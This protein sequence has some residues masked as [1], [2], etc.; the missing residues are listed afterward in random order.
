MNYRRKAYQMNTHHT[1]R[2]RFGKIEK[3]SFA[4]A[5]AAHRAAEDRI[6]VI[7]EFFSHYCNFLHVI[8]EINYTPL[9]NKRHPGFLFR[10]H[11]SEGTINLL[12]FQQKNFFHLFVTYI[13]LMAC[14][15][16]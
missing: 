8:Y 11:F 14:K 6:S 3:S 12:I 15:L 1:K 9:R 16:L 10:Q 7:G 5:D 4:A 13:A 2:L